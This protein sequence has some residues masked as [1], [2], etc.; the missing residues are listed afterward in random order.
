MLP[1]GFGGA[2]LV[3]GLNGIEE[4]EC[5]LVGLEKRMR[6]KQFIREMSYLVLAEV[7]TTE[8]LILEM[9]E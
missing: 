9:C 7:D 3:V 4:R 8:I 5:H 6:V 2:F 1:R